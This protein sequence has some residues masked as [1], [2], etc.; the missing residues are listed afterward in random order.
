VKKLL[1]SQVGAEPKKII[2]LGVILAGAGVAYFVNRTPS[3]DV[4]VT[5]AANV[6]PDPVALKSMPEPAARNSAPAPD[7]RRVSKSG[8]TTGSSDN[9]RPS[10]KPKDG[11]DVTRTD[12]TL[13]LDLLAKVREVGVEGGAR[14]LFDF[15]PAPPPPLPKID[16]ITVP[17]PMVG[18]P[19]PPAPPAPPP[20]P[21][22]PPKPPPPPI[23]LKFYGFAGKPSEGPR[24]GFFLSGDPATGDLYVAAEGETVKDRY[25]VVRFGV[26]SVDMEDTTTE[27]VQK[28][29]LVE[30]VKQ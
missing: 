22:E 15:S 6:T 1:P 16:P 25:K 10:L 26:N 29:P 24:R 28:L 18:P 13:R 2:I 7:T 30:E 14:S 11:V 17:P 4:P 9:F 23:P 20:K 12:P 19:T 5:V 21:V 3:P 27:S 8:I